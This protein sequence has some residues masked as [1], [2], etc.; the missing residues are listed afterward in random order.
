VK[1]LSGAPFFPRHQRPS[2]TNLHNT[3]FLDIARKTQKVRLG[4][5]GFSEILELNRTFFEDACCND[6]VDLSVTKIFQDCRDIVLLAVVLKIYIVVKN[7]L[8]TSLN[9]CKNFS[10]SL[11]YYK[12]V[13]L[14]SSWPILSKQLLLLKFP[15][16][17]TLPKTF[18]FNHAIC[19]MFK[20]LCRCLNK[21]V[22]NWT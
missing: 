11:I 20:Y 14:Q 7:I 21:A 19:L 13:S 4:Q 22:F 16:L 2:S 8:V 9:F 3:I 1:H 12:N 10:A 5:A 17:I 6:D 18:S 15:I